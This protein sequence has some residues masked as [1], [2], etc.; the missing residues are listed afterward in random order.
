M[1]FKT[2]LR[3]MFWTVVGILVAAISYQVCGKAWK[4]DL[5]KIQLA[6]YKSG[7][8]LDWRGGPIG[9]ERDSSKRSDSFAFSTG[10]TA[11]R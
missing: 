9:A 11:N 5:A 1:M 6:N 7:Q 10:W 3:P 2:A 8:S 4:R